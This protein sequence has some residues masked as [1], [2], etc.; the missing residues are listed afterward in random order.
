MAY[1]CMIWGFA[2]VTSKYGWDCPT[3]GSVLTLATQFQRIL[4][5]ILGPELLLPS[6]LEAMRLTDMLP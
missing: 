4:L 5:V 3:C 1:A 6:S 2:S